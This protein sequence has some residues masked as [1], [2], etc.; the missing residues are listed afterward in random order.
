MISRRE[1]LQAAVAASALMTPTS[2]SLA[3]MASAQQITQSDLLDFDDFGNVTLVHITDIHAQA[4]PVYFREP[5]INIG[6]G[7]VNG[8]PPHITGQDFLN[9]FKLNPGSPD[10][11]ALSSEDFVALARDYGRMGG[12]DRV[13]TVIRHIRSTREANMLLLDGG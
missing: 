7:E 6:V 4:K 5:S 13:A 1:F 11:Y 12:L 2:R 9:R 10:A 3:A 8:L